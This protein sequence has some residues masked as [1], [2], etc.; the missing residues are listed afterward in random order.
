V[1]R[2]LGCPWAGYPPL[3]SVYTQWGSAMY[4]TPAD[5]IALYEWHTPRQITQHTKAPWGPPESW[6]MGT[7]QAINAWS[8]SLH[9]AWRNA[10]EEAESPAENFERSDGNTT[11][12]IPGTKLPAVRSVCHY[13]NASQNVT[14]LSVSAMYLRDVQ[15]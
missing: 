7:Q 10:I 4:I 3:L 13:V 2:S 6:A 11:T 8:G 12:H 15:P 1:P 14:N 5:P 9:I